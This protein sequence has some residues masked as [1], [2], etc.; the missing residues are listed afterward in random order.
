MCLIDI[1]ESPAASRIFEAEIWSAD[2]TK[3]QIKF[4]SEPVVTIKHIRQICKLKRPTK[5]TTEGNPKQKKDDEF[6]ISPDERT[7]LQLE[8]KNYPEYIKRG[9]NIIIFEG[10][11][12]AFG[13][14]TD[15]IK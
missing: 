6:T 15:I 10:C 9:D 4:K 14:I 12:K 1:N 5:T 8:F 7:L 13:V 2:G 3:R 11:F